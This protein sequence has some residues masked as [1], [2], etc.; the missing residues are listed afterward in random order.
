MRTNIQTI[1]EN[2]KEQLKQ[3]G[4]NIKTLCSI[5]KTDRLYI[6]RMTDRAPIEKIINIAHAI[7]CEPSELLKGT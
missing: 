3:R 6:Y 5:L 1:K 4:S 7:G 2:I